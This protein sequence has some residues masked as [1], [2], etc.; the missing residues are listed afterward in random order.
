MMDQR[1]YQMLEKIIPVING[2][3]FAS[4]ENRDIVIRNGQHMKALMD[5]FRFQVPIE[6]HENALYACLNLI[7][8]CN[9]A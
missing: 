5:V 7:Q 8:D 2:L 4:S 6:L 3:L 9:K 1:Q